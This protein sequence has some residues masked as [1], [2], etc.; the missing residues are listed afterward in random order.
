MIARRLLLY[1]AVTLR[2]MV[3]AACDQFSEFADPVV[4][5]GSCRLKELRHNIYILGRSL[6][7]HPMSCIQ[8]F[9][10]HVRKERLA[11]RQVSPVDIL[12]V[13]SLDEERRP[14]PC[15]LARDVREVSN[16]WHAG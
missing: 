5:H 15:H 10:L 9:Q 13:F 8:G 11:V 3:L 4:L 14:V 12:R 1:F 6:R 16:R 7:M 2:V